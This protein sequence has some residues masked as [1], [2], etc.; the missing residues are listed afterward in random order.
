MQWVPCPCPSWESSPSMKDS[1][2][3]SRPAKSGCPASKPVSS[4]ATRMPLPV[5][6]DSAA[7]TACNPQVC[8]SVSAKAGAADVSGAAAAG[9]IR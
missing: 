8:V 4:T 7:S 2:V 6:P 3:T 9:R 5:Y 1:V